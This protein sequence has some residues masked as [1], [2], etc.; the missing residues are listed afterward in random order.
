MLVVM[1]RILSPNVQAHG[2]FFTVAVVDRAMVGVIKSKTW[3]AEK[4]RLPIPFLSGCNIHSAPQK[5]K[6]KVLSSE[7]IYIQCEPSGCEFRK[8]MNLLV[9]I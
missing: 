3:Q 5:K 2:L 4:Q 6:K 8:N 7:L 1:D 9:P